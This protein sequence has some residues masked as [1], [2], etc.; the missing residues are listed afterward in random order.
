MNDQ[1]MNLN[2][3][4][5]SANNIDGNSVPMRNNDDGRTPPLLQRQH[6]KGKIVQT[7]WLTDFQYKFEA[8]SRACSE[9]ANGFRHLQEAIDTLQE[10]PTPNVANLLEEVMGMP[11]RV[12]P[13]ASIVTNRQMT[14][15]PRHQPLNGNM[16]NGANTPFSNFATPTRP[17]SQF[18][19]AERRTNSSVHSTPTMPQS[20]SGNKQNWTSS[21]KPSTYTSMRPAT[22]TPN[23]GD[24]GMRNGGSA[25]PDATASIASASSEE[26]ENWTQEER[27]ALNEEFIRY[28]QRRKATEPITHPELA[29]ELLS[30]CVTPPPLAHLDRQVGRYLRRHT[31]PCDSIVLHAI[32]QWI[33]KEKVARGE[34]AVAFHE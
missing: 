34:V 17:E 31:I 32:Q 7:M 2:G 15:T 28:F 3:T 4:T 30:L 18:Q 23:P 22:P 25:S 10:T 19:N 6:Q 29:D 27:K 20:I 33:D 16:T 26:H 5:S 13:P 14:P 12:R 24:S 9:V 11:L 8:I 21:S 1:Y